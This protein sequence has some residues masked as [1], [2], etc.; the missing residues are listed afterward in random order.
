M[1]S[2]VSGNDAFSPNQKASLTQGI[3]NIESSF[4]KSMDSLKQDMHQ[5]FAKETTN[6]EE[7]EKTNKSNAEGLE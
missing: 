2:T 7:L 3:G 6:V 5:Q 4:K 1:K